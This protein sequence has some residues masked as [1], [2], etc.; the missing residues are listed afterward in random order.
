MNWLVIVIG[1]L[2]VW[3]LIEIL[4]HLFLRKTAKVFIT[5]LIFVILFLG[6]SKVMVDSSILPKE[7]GVITT[8]ATIAD[9]IIQTFSKEKTE[10][11]TKPINI[12]KV[13]ND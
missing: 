7:N 3:I 2:V 13:I 11:K 9:K 5:I 8:G 12:T 6:I 1:L 4:K 10:D